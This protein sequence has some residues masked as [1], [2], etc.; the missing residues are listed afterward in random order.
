MEERFEYAQK[1]GMLEIGYKSFN[2]VFLDEVGFCVVMRHKCE[3][4][5]IGTIHYVSELATRRK[6][7]VVAAFNKYGMMYY[8][9]F[10]F[11]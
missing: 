6:Y 2:F 4:S 3:M 1:P 9:I 7:F 11:Y 5:R 10:D 8:M